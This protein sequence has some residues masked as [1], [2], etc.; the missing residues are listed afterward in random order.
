[1]PLDPRTAPP[2]E[3]VQ[4]YTLCFG[5][6][7]GKVVLADLTLFVEANMAAQKDLQQRV[8]P[9]QVVGQVAAERVLKRIQT[10][11]QMGNSH[12]WLQIDAA[13][14]MVAAESKL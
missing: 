9:Y 1:M 5:N 2:R 11:A 14:Q 4:A 8:D 12:D 3:L 13:R 6:A 7:A 10:M